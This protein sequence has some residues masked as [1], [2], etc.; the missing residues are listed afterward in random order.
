MRAWSSFTIPVA[1]IGI[2]GGTFDPIHNGHLEA[3]RELVQRADLE[4]VWLMPNAHPPHRH[5]PQA[6]AEDRA[7]M[8]ELAVVGEAHLVASRLEVDRGGTSYTIDTVRELGERFPG[9]RFELLLGLDAAEQVQRWHRGGELLAQAWF[10]IFNRPGRSP[11]ARAL[12]TLGFESARTRIVQLQTPDISA[13]AIRARLAAGQPI[14]DL[15]P[16][17][18]VDYIRGR[19]LYT[20]TSARQLG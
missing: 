10:V 12:E 11:D 14:N 19:H 8:V 6:S 7:R 20:P 18:V 2:L 4:Q 17:A 16:P 9:Q 3:A 5:E 13:H 1:S 15:V